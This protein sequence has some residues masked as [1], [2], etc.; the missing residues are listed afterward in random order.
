MYGSEA[1]SGKEIELDQRNR[2]K[3][4]QN[5]IAVSRLILIIKEIERVKFIFLKESLRDPDPCIVLNF[6]NA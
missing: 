2:L 1:A 4:K 6:G 5:I 3:G